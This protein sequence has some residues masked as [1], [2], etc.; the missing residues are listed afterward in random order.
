[1][2]SAWIIGAGLVIEFFFILWLTK[3]SIPR[4]C[5]M[6]LAMNVVSTIVGIFGIPL[7]GLA[8]EFVAAVTVMPIFGW[9]TFNPVTWFASCVL[10]A[11]LNALVETGSLRL[12]FKT[13]WSKRI[14]W[15]LVVVN[16]VTVGISMASIMMQPPEL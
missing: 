2:Q 10:A 6:T 16:L 5:L 4:A 13:T 15:W 11:L 3:A 9:G 8:W 14:F 1:M 7:S 12:V